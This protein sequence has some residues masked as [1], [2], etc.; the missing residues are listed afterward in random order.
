M[1]PRRHFTHFPIHV[2][3][4]LALLAAAGVASGREPAEAGLRLL[5]DYSAKPD[6]RQLAV[7]NFAI[8]DPAADVDLPAAHQAGGTVLAYVATVE[9][10]PESPHAGQAKARGLRLQG[11]N[12]GWATDVLDVTDPAWMEFIV[13]D[14]AAAAVAKGYDGLFLDTLDSVA[15]IAKQ[16]PAKGDACHRALVALI[17][18][19]RQRFPDKQIVLNRGFDLVREVRHD[20]QGVMAESLYQSW[21]PSL[22]QYREVGAEDRKW[23]LARLEEARA[24]GLRVFV[25]DYAPADD[26]ATAMVTAQKIAAHGFVPFVSTPELSGRAL[27]PCREMPRLM[28][29][30]RGKMPWREPATLAIASGGAERASL[31]AHSPIPD[32]TTRDG[33]GL[34][35]SEGLTMPTLR[36]LLD[37]TAAS[38]L[39]KLSAAQIAD[40]VR[41]AEQARIYELSP[42]RWLIS[43]A[44]H[45][46]TFRLDARAG[47]P[48]MT[49]SKG[50]SG[51]VVDGGDLYVHTQGLP[52]TEI[53]LAEKL[54]PQLHLVRAT[55]DLDFHTLTANA[56]EFTVKGRHRARALFA[57]IRP[58]APCELAVNGHAMTLKADPE[59]RV[60]LA[61]PANARVKLLLAADN[62][63]AK[64]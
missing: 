40:I 59:G 52:I 47:R 5:V 27:A 39:R 7:F 13:E 50:L 12:E 10:R 21:G 63:A 26:P 44:G 28:L 49:T 2:A 55:A 48:D 62:Y 57:G 8:L 38:P 43:S 18:R 31:P 53:V 16:Q 35:S 32:T 23:L 11:R 58:L 4:A 1:R 25:L 34:A 15:L 46:R 60:S 19:L 41:D 30:P 24:A 6:P 17:H 64:N 61:L 37:W 42:K 9:L 45:L 56:A 20:I 3:S 33:C 36:G 22:G 29:V 51:Y 14:V 54:P